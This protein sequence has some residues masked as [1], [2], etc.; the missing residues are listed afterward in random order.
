MLH[1]RDNCVIMARLGQVHIYSPPF[2]LSASPPPLLLSASPPPLL[3]SS[4]PPLLISSPPTPPSLLILFSSRCAGPTPPAATRRSTSATRG[5][6]PRQVTG[7]VQSSVW[8]CC[9][10]GLDPVLEVLLPLLPLLL[11]LMLADQAS[12]VARMR[13]AAKAAA[14]TRVRSTCEEPQVSC[15][16]HSGQFAPY[17]RGSFQNGI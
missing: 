9:D 17:F 8:I 2:L 15:T 16:L 4:P 11:H 7:F 5:R 6:A 12:V 13:R 14:S 10:H 3:L 1:V